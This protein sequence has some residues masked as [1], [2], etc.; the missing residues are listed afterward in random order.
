M[1]STD[2]AAGD[3]ARTAPDSRLHPMSSLFVLLQHLRQF[4]LPLVI[5][6]LFGRGDR[7]ELWGLVAVTLLA[8]ASIWQYYT[9]RYRIESG[10]L[11]IRSG[12]LERNARHIP[13]ARIHN[14]A[15]RQTLL[16]RLFGVA[17]VRLESAGGRRP[18][19]QMRV[20]SL[21]QALALEALIRDHAQQAAAPAGSD[22]AMAAPAQAQAETQ[23]LLRLPTA[24]VVRLGLISNRGL[25][26]VAGAFAAVSQV[27]RR[28]IGDLAERGGLA[29]ARYFGAHTVSTAQAAITLALVVIVVL[30]G[31]RLLS[32]TLALL[33]YHDFTLRRQGRRLSVERG[34]LSRNRSNVPARRIQSWLLQEGVLQRAF[35]RRSLQVETA[36]AFSHSSEHALRE[37][38]PVATPQRCDAL[39]AELL[40]AALWPPREWQ[41]ID[42]HA[43]WRMAL[44][45]LIAS[46]WL[47]AA[48]AWRYGPSGWWL[49][50]LGT[51]ALY[52][53]WGHALRTGYSMGEELIAV[54]GGWWRRYWRF[55]ERDKL[56][57]L[58]LT[59]N[60]LDRALGTATVWLDTA[61]SN[62]AHPALRM[63]YLPMARAQAMFDVLS[64][65]IMRRP[66]RW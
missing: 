57:A 18:E 16:H 22:P 48:A 13:F 45:W 62:P 29:L 63:R 32:V 49:L 58:R 65:D 31:M 26:V 4:V 23:V 27:D 39:A 46:V 15:L 50:S 28:L 14:V 7:N 38:A 19:A 43:W 21:P 64:A 6:L 25:V 34:L 5:L 3:G 51:L 24:E 36:V 44:P 53:G 20:L 40:G 12:L 54:R 52:T 66:L 37:L 33:Q 55:A 8:S 56:Q 42:R 41:P 61:G 60:P 9:Y 47:A 1:P 35:E 2:R 11:V 30:I 59:R 10:A 17:E